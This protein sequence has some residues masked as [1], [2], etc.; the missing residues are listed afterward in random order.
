MNIEL[1]IAR[2]GRRCDWLHFIADDF[3]QATIVV[4]SG[5]TD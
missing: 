3:P 4:A 2:T 5:I 1:E